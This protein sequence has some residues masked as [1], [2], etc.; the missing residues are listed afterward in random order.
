MLGPTLLFEAP[1]LQ[2]PRF[3]PVLRGRVH[4]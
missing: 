3:F 4:A 2:A 1:C